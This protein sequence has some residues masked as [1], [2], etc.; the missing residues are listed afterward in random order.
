[1]ISTDSVIEEGLVIE[2]ENIEQD[3][4]DVKQLS[5]NQV[6]INQQPRSRKQ[7]LAAVITNEN[8][9]EVSDKKVTRRKQEVI[10]STPV[11]TRPTRASARAVASVIAA[12]LAAEA[13]VENEENDQDRDM[14]QLT[15]TETEV[16]TVTTQEKD[17]FEEKEDNG[18]IED[19]ATNASGRGGKRKAATKSA[20][21]SSQV[22]KSD[23]DGTSPTRKSARIARK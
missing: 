3:K 23:E 22:T 8:D 17:I 20:K 19:T 5:G 16:T 12:E 1:V 6:S 15:E 18:E 4:N 7:D 10:T 21:T 9:K 14:I 13:E 11:S 2:Q